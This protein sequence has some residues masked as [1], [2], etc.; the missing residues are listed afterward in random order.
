MLSKNAFRLV[1]VL[2]V[3]GPIVAAR[4]YDSDGDG[5]DD[6][7]DVC[8][9]TPE[10]TPVDE[11]GRPVG[12]LDRDC[13]V[14]ILDFAILQAA[15]TGELYPCLPCDTSDDCVGDDYCARLYSDCQRQG[16]CSPR[17]SACQDVWEP[18]CGCDAETYENSCAAA[19]AGASIH[20]E[21]ECLPSGCQANMHCSA[22]EF[23]D[24]EVGDCDGMGLCQPRPS[25]C[26]PSGPTV[27][28]CDGVTYGD[29]C[30]A[31]LADASI[32]HEGSC[33]P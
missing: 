27:C 11:Q 16:T 18:V 30:Y 24:K 15:F 32:A 26:V 20:Y 33:P 14:D 21:G 12:D 29:S 31:A 2:A 10:G 4:A 7:L 23:C 25:G 22:R 19:L 3:A 6:H 28:G 9:A 1:I 13:D 17:P 5:V 8:C